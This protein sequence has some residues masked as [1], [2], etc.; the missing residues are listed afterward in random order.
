MAILSL[1]L[2]DRKRSQFATLGK[3]ALSHDKV[4][5]EVGVAARI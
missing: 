5:G 2:V 1:L 4:S 3:M